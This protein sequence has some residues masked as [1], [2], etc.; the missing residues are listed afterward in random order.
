MRKRN[1]AFGPKVLLVQRRRDSERREQSEQKL[2]EATASAKQTV[3]QKRLEIQGEVK[4]KHPA[5]SPGAAME[6]AVDNRAAQG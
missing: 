4:S 2:H 5:E 3:N 6:R 1:R